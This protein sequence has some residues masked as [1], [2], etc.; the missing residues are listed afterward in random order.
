L[1]ASRFLTGL[2]E[3]EQAHVQLQWAT[4]RQPEALARM[5]RLE[6]DLDHLQRAGQLLIGY[7]LKCSDPAILAAARKNQEAAQAAIAAATA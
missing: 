7:Q 4:R 5:K 2:T 1:H 6:S 3:V